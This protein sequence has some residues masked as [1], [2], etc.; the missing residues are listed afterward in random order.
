M[1]RNAK[2][3]GHG[4]RSHGSGTL[5]RRKGF[6]LARWTVDG[7]RFSQALGTADRAEA[8]RR[9]AAIT[10][11]FRLAT[12]EERLQL[13][14][15]KIEGT[16][17][18]RKRIEDEAPAVRIADA[19]DIYAESPERPE[20]S[21]KY[22]ADG[23]ARWRTFASFMAERYPAVT[24]LRHVTR[25]HAAAFM[26]EYGKTRS[27]YTYNVTRE[28]ALRLWAFM[29]DQPGAKLPPAAPCPFEKIAR[30]RNAPTPRRALTADELARVC[31]YVKGEYRALFAIG[32]YTGLRLKDC[33]LLKWGE[34]RPPPPS[35]HRHP[36]QD[37]AARQGCIYPDTPRLVRR[38][39]GNAR[40]EAARVRAA[41]DRGGLS[42][43]G[44]TL[45]QGGGDI[46]GLRHRDADGRRTGRRAEALH[47]RLPFPAAHLRV[48][49]RERGSAAGGCAE[50]RRAR[51][52]E[53]DRALLPRNYSRP[54]RRRL[55]AAGRAGG[56]AAADSRPPPAVGTGGRIGGNVRPRPLQG[57]RRRPAP[58]RRGGR[59]GILDA[60]RKVRNGGDHR[61]AVKRDNGR[62]TDGAERVEGR[63]RRA[64]GN[65]T[66]GPTRQGFGGRRT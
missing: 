45:G 63:F 17:Q 30:R 3:N 26:A 51:L 66:D 46:Q 8:E 50:D 35:R 14:A 24:E 59:Y 61:R 53:D 62:Q 16:R 27:A 36:V 31:S 65:E 48:N 42:R 34:R 55:P 29:A 33:C 56:N 52:A 2:K 21:E 23:A 20:T 1:K 4:R 40:A 9:L 12:D 41:E 49:G 47:S 32:I 57:R 6:W 37:G 43:R 13:M 58:L 18:E 11:P 15:A 10:A 54:K 28:Q 5:E 39:G 64:G 22:Q 44:H 7:R 60:T 25:E 19:W 38:A